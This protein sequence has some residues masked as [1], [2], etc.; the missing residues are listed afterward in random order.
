MLANMH[1]AVV[2]F[3]RNL[4]ETNQVADLATV[5]TRPTAFVSRTSDTGS[6]FSSSY[7][8]LLFTALRQFLA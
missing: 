7:K 4:T 6:L 2:P 1:S 8:I 5:E 3:S